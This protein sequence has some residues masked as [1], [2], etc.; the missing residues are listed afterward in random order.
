MAK[1][2]NWIWW[3]IG[4]LSV[5]GLGV[6]AYIF[7]KDRKDKKSA[8]ATPEASTTPTSYTPPPSS[9]SSSSSSSPSYP[10]TP[11]KNREEGDK[12]RG[13]V[14]DKYPDYAKSLDLERSN[15]LFNNTTIRKAWAKYG[16]EYQL[17]GGA[18]QPASASAS[19]SLSL[20]QIKTFLENGGKTKEIEIDWTNNRVRGFALNG[21]G[22][23]VNNIYVNLYPDGTIYFEN[24]L[25]SDKK[26]GK[27]STSGDALAIEVGGN[28]EVGQGGWAAY[29]MAKKLYPSVI[30]F[31]S[32]SYSDFLFKP[33]KKKYIDGCDANL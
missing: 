17:Q 6:G 31:A 19:S 9:S 4:G 7:F 20:Q 24:G 30:E 15:K 27:W 5:V 14:N 3:T 28:K 29:Y 1:G 10:S 26:S 2:S 22:V 32:E 13:W 21:T 23:G 25:D 11:F 8:E 18:N 16:S 33:K 12:F